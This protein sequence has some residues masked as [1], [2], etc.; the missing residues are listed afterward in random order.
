MDD[1]QREGWKVVL[2]RSCH[3]HGEEHQV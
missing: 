1:I 3:D 2:L